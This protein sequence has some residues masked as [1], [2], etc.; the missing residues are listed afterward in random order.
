LDL[1]E[2]SELFRVDPTESEI[3]IIMLPTEELLISPMSTLVPTPEPTPLPEVD[4]FSRLVLIPMLPDDMILEVL[5]AAS[6]GQG[7]ELVIYSSSQTG[8]GIHDFYADILVGRGWSWVYTDE[9]ISH[10]VIFPSHT[11]VSEYRLDDVWMSIVVVADTYGF[12]NTVDSAGSLV[13]VATNLTGGDVMMNVSNLISSMSGDTVMEE[14]AIEPKGMRFTSN[15]LQFMHPS[16]WV[17]TRSTLGFFT[18]DA[19]DSRRIHPLETSPGCPMIDETCFINFMLFDGSHY[20]PSITVRIYPNQNGTTLEE[21]DQLRWA[22]LNGITSTAAEEYGE[23]LRPEELALS[24]SLENIGILH[25]TLEDGSPALQRSYYWLQI[26]QADRLL[27]TN[28]LINGEES[29]IEIHTDFTS[30]EWVAKGEMIHNA[31]LTI[32]VNSEDEVSD[33]VCASYSKQPESE[34]YIQ[35]SWTDDPEVTE[36]LES[37]F[38]WADSSLLGKSQCAQPGDKHIII[39]LIENSRHSF[40]MPDD[41]DATTEF[42]TDATCP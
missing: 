26:E 17:A 37:C 7:S 15:H 32:R 40:D 10:A 33:L 23:V 35:G 16:N 11:L 30:A 28:T 29:I 36:S 2:F 38:E 5:E 13:M 31:I 8:I 18:T 20:S 1:P 27:S 6:D 14:Y 24:G 3:T 22:E 12:F 4:P 42:V 41:I 19:G 34:R 39:V 21:F 25:F 9:G